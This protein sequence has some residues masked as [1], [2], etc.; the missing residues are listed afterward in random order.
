M[1]GLCC[2]ATEVLFANDGAVSRLQCRSK[3]A[4]KASSTSETPVPTLTPPGRQIPQNRPTASSGHGTAGVSLKVEFDLGLG[5]WS[6]SLN[7]LPAVY[8]PPLLVV[9]RRSPL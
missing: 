5:A 4:T 9:P 6:L 8:E 7:T 3:V 2:I 1:H